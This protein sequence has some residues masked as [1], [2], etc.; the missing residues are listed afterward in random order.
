MM[1]AIMVN[2]GSEA[3]TSLAVEG[4]GSGEMMV[5]YNRKFFKA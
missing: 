3:I 2:F 5:S 1:G 4:I